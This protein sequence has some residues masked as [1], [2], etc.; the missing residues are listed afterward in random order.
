VRIR[1]G[2]VKLAPYVKDPDYIPAVILNLAN[3]LT[4]AACFELIYTT[5]AIRVVN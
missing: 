2:R 3:S 4:T 1:V 5:S